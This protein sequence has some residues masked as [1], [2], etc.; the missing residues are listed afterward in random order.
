MITLLS[1]MG[2]INL[3]WSQ[4]ARD[5][6]LEA[7][8]E[9]AKGKPDLAGR[10]RGEQFPRDGG[11]GPVLSDEETAKVKGETNYR[12]LSP[13]DKAQYNTDWENAHKAT[14]AA[15]ANPTAANHGAAAVAHMKAAGS[16][17]TPVH[18]AAHLAQAEEHKLFNLRPVNRGKRGK[19]RIT[20]GNLRP[21]S[22]FQK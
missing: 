13:S 16:S 20:I 19:S 1:R 17:P 7:R 12:L 14:M 5:A 3:A 18:R 11:K 2:I 22:H 15:S 8:R 6:A 9:H 10:L 21:F 4:E